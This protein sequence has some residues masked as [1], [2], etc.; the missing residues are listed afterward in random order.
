MRLLAR[1]WSLA[2]A[3]VD[4]LI[5]GRRAVA[6]YGASI[7]P[8]YVPGSVLQYGSRQLLGLRQG[9]NGGA[10][11]YAST[12]E[13][14]L[15]VICSS[16]IATAL[17]SATQI[18]PR[19]DG[20]DYAIPAVFLAVLIAGLALSLLFR[21]LAP[22]IIAQAAIYQLVFFSG[23][24]ALA[25]A[26][27]AVLGIEAQLLPAAGGLFLLSWLIGFCMPLAPGGLGVR[28]AAGVALLSGLA[29]VETALLLL[30]SMR[31][32]TLIGDCLIFVVAL[33]FQRNLRALA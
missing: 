28:E 3:S 13:V 23:L 25:I 33:T 11:A 26:C 16:T 8:K 18:A 9:M 20:M 29:G 19:L 2:P 14:V 24:A 31:L 32:I 17:L 7:L 4:P 5:G 21:R 6:V 1:S 30:L 10:M 27:G 12:L 22:T 15:H